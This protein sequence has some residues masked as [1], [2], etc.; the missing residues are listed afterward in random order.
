MTRSL[1]QR[2][3]AGPRLVHPEC[4]AASRSVAVEP[5]TLTPS[6]PDMTVWR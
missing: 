1:S 4:G 2:R 5:W 6:A 3:N